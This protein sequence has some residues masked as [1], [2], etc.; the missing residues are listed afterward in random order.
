MQESER[1]KD[2]ITAYHCKV[3]ALALLS[4]SVGVIATPSLAADNPFASEPDN[5]TS[6]PI[7][8]KTYYVG[9]NAPRGSQSLPLSTWVAGSTT[10]SFTFT[11]ASGTKVFNISFSAL[12]DLNNGQGGTTPFY[13]NITGATTTAINLAHNSPVSSS[14]KTNHILSIS[15]NRNVSKMGYKIQDVDST[16]SNN[17]T[18]YI[19]QVD[20]SAQ[21][22]RLS[23]LPAFHT[24]N[25]ARDIIT[26]IKGKNCGAGACN[27]DASWNYNLS[28]SAVSLKHNNTRSEINNPHAVA[29]SDFYF[30]LAPP[31]LIVKKSLSN[32]RVDDNDQ[33]EIAVTGDGVAANA[34]VTTGTK[35]TLD[36]NSSAVLS[37]KENTRYTIS[38][39]VINDQRDSD[40]TDYNATY[41]CTNATTGSTSVMPTGTG[42]SFTLANVNYGDEIT[43]TL[44]NRPNYIFSGTVFNDNGGI[45]ASESSKH[46]VSSKFTGN[47]HYFNGIFDNDEAGIFHPNLN[48]SLTDCN[49]TLIAP[50]ANAPNPQ[51]VS[52]TGR[53]KF[54]VPPATLMGRNKVCLVQNEP[55]SWE[56]AVDTTSNTQ[57]VPLLTNTYGYGRLDFGEVETNNSAL[58][59]KKYQY[60]HACNDTLNYTATNINRSTPTQP[61]EGFSTN[62]A[63]DIKPGNCIAYKIEAHNRG[64]IYLADVQISDILQNGAVMSVFH[65][66]ASTGIAATMHKT[67]KTTSP[68]IN[69]GENGAIISSTFNLPLSAPKATL[70]FNSKYGIAP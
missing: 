17:Q 68:L 32:N 19:E 54:T 18:P 11:E 35:A 38:E 42:H 47:S 34:F 21:A 30:C 64:H 39:R 62:S 69:M 23:H 66:P 7:N 28:N 52:S 40:I 49:G 22:G 37:L 9:A 1:I 33:F 56:Y 51:T 31:K 29:Y 20:V 65:L 27:V 41:S 13:G 6:C 58:V 14:P 24:I 48:I 55:S 26:A 63:N 59:L 3:A 45:D 44:T 10:R 12:A 70:Y 2:S 60:V 46:D 53:Y 61:S 16:T 5:T 25:T 4:L 50:A 8:H 67:N 36:N 57:E 15:V 43:C